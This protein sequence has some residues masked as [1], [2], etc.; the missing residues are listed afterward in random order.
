VV[1]HQIYDELEEIKEKW[2]GS[3]PVA[4]LTAT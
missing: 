1:L 4:Q 2:A 3:L